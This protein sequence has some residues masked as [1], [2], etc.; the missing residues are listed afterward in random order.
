MIITKIIILV[1]YIL[2]V[3]IIFGSSFL[4]FELFR[5]GSRLRATSEITK[6]YWNTDSS[7]L[8][9]FLFSL[10]IGTFWPITIPIFL[11]WKDPII[12]YFIWDK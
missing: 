2:I 10:V 8:R 11:I 4:F 7:I 12:D 6:W 5:S 1:I 9:L 3:G